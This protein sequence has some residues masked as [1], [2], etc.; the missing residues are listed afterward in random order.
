MFPEFWVLVP[1]HEMVCKELTEENDASKLSVV[2][3]RFERYVWG[4]GGKVALA[5]AMAG[6]SVLERGGP[7]GR[8]R[9]RGP[10]DTEE[11]VWVGDALNESALRALLQFEG[12]SFLD[13]ACSV[14]T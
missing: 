7:R 4:D 8:D 10:V 6:T 3:E 1:V 11:V 12:E 5:C 13:R 2:A 9:A 14:G